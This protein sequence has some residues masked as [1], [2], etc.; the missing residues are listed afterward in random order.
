M[1]EVLT[2]WATPSGGGKYSVMYFDESNALTDIRSELKSMWDAMA[3]VLDTET[4]YTVRTTGRII[5]E[6]TGALT[7]EWSEPT[8]KTGA[9]L[10]SGQPLADAT[11]A[12]IRWNTGVVVGGRFLKGRTFV[13]GLSSTTSNNGNVSPAAI[14]A[15][16]TGAAFMGP[17]GAQLGVWHRPKGG[18]GGALHPI[19]SS[20]VWTEFAVLRRR[21]G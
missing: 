11:Q 5:D 10:A 12:L 19:T 7:G 3:S 8:L 15:L 17:A 6:V 4:V 1:Y 16:Q 13:P 18:T 2:N 21:R 9:G 20:S 14:T